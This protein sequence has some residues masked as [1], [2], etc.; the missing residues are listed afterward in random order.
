MSKRKPRKKKQAF[1]YKWYV[2]TA[3]LMVVLIVASWLLYKKYMLDKARWV[4]YPAFGIEIPDN[5]QIH[6]IDVSWYQNFI[7]WPSVKSM[8]VSKIKIGFTFIKA[9]EGLSNADKQ[10]RR[11]WKK[12]KDAGLPRGAYHF[13]LPHK[14]GKIQA[15]N[16][17]A[18]VRLEP[19]DLPPVLDV[20]HLYGTNPATM[21]KEAKQWLITVE[22]HYKVKPI[23]YTS[24][25]FYTNYLDGEFDEYPLWAA[26][27]LEKNK[28]RIK[29]PW[30]FW[31]HNERGRVNGIVTRV[32]FNVF[33]GD[34]TD[35]ENI[36]IR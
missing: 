9:T 14:S 6:G 3:L 22:N 7:D 28:P 20:E 21:R 16:F 13:F 24:V 5:Y 18:N 36:L 25:S 34:S 2:V 27:Y 10:F 1:R 17:I 33:N 35:F 19:G 15:Q 12:S 8:E 29:R 11:N 23:I 26:H 30:L 32:D 31:Q 4:K